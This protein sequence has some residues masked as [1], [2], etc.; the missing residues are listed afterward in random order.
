MRPNTRSS[1]RDG[2]KIGGTRLRRQS[3]MTAALLIGALVLAGCGSHAKAKPKPRAQLAPA[4]AQLS[5]FM[6]KLNAGV[7]PPQAAILAHFSPK[8]LKVVP[9]AQMLQAL[10]P[11]AVERPFRLES[12]LPGASPLGLAV[13]Y[14]GQRGTTIRMDVRVAKSPPHRITGLRI[15]LVPTTFSS[16]KAI[17]RTLAT[18]GSEPSYLAAEVVNGKL[19]TIHAFNADR[20]GAVGSAFKLYVLGALGQAIEA[21]QAS[22][23]EKLAIR[24][25]WKSIP[26]GTMQ[27]QPAGTRWTLQ[28]YARQMISI[29]DNTATDRLIYRLGRLAVEKEL[30]R[31][32]N[33]A[34]AQ[35]VP[36]LTT[37]ENT[38]LKVDAPA[39]LRNA[40]ARAGSAERGRLL[41]WVDA[42]PLSLKD[43][44]WNK[45]IDI[46]SIEWFASPA[47]LGRALVG[48][49]K[50]SGRP[51]L[52]PIRSILAVNSGLPFEPSVWP[53]V[54]YKGG[55]EEGVV[56][57]AW[58][59]ERADGRVFVF[60]YVLNDPKHLIDEIAPSALALSAI[61]RLAHG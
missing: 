41:K 36:F 31:F 61:N 15:R 22:W 49:H 30:V 53:Y 11:L 59:L 24:D 46:G 43:V 8:F 26:S 45:P 32:G 16:W 34:A 52:A 38:I 29:S 23:S 17:D 48:L 7:A 39:S 12:R 51:G 20:A 10:Q 33:R 47:D 3:L 58:Y 5:W 37:R 25:A 40:Y 35:D 42:I 14:A 19:R 9:V 57:G 1:E 54:G 21:K 13:R 4:A 44:I 18:F 60:T 28:H 27:N 56:S 6:R 2:S 50:L 55:S